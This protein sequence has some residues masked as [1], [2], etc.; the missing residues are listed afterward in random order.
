[1]TPRQGITI[2]QRRALRRRAHRQHPKP[3]QKQ[4]IE[5]FLQEYNHKLSQSTVSESLSTHFSHLDDC[6]NSESKRLREGFWPDLEKVL[7]TWQVRIEERGGVT[8]GELLR[9][10]AREIWYQLPQYADK[11]APEFSVGWLEGFKKRFN[12]SLRVRH[13][14]AASIPQSAEEEMKALQTVAGEYEE[15]DIYNMDESALF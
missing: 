9:A 15:E 13:G 6:T 11:P 4:C 3:T 10:K 5:W 2:E 8:S 7:F 14:E 12:I 1:M